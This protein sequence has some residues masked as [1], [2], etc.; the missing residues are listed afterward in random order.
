LNQAAADAN[1][2][3]L[4]DII[5]QKTGALIR[6]AARA[7]VIIGGGDDRRL[8]AADDYAAALGL[9]FQIKDDLLDRVGDSAVLGKNTASD[10]HNGK[11]TT[12]DLYGGEGAEGMIT[13]LTEKALA[14]LGPFEDKGPLTWLARML[15]GREN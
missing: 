12:F 7:G 6:A 14:S 1:E 4:L 9:A 8:A 5:S 11:V 13:G 10:L 15:L 3:T 2:Q